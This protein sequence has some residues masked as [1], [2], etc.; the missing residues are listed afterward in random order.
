MKQSVPIVA[1]LLALGLGTPMLADAEASEL[2]TP[3]VALMPHVSKLEGA[4]DLNAEQKARLAA[5]RAEAPARRKALEAEAL[6]TRAQLREAI[7]GGADRMQREALK[8]RLAEQRNRLIEMRSLCTRMLRQTLNADQ[9]AK[10]VASYRA[11]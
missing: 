2:G 9:F 10:V 5:W 7:L 11:G 4:L 1:T 3:V 8:R 6:A